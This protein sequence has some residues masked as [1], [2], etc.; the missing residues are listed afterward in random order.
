MQVVKFVLSYGI[1][2][3]AQGVAISQVLNNNHFSAGHIL[4]AKLQADAEKTDDD[5]KDFHGVAVF[6]ISF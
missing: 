4:T 6:E 5:T 2:L 1:T 3:T